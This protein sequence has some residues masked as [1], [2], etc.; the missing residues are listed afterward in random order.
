MC[1]EEVE[2]G[3]KEMMGERGGRRGKDMGKVMGVG[4]KKVGG[5]GEGGGRSLGME[6]EIVKWREVGDGIG[7]L[8]WSM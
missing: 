2:G 8:K 5:V 4:R 3:L 6:G 1:G 7:L